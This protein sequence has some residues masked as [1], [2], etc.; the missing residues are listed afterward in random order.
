MFESIIWDHL[1]YVLQIYSNNCHSTIQVVWHYP[2]RV[3]QTSLATAVTNIT[4][5]VTKNNFGPS[6]QQ[7]VAVVQ[8]SRPSFLCGPTYFPEAIIGCGRGGRGKG[9]RDSWFI[10][11]DTF[12]IESRGQ[13]F[14]SLHLSL[15]TLHCATAISCWRR[16]TCKTKRSHISHL[17]VSIS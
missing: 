5:P 7:E 1:E 4:K 9:E 15:C 16:S 13:Y 14:V 6:T 11:G 3:G 10:G 8:G 12:E 2:S 17:H